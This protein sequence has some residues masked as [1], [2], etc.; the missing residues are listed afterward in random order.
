M[1]DR[2][3]KKTFLTHDSLVPDDLIEGARAHSLGQRCARGRGGERIRGWR[4]W[5]RRLIIEQRRCHDAL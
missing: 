3:A 4:L 5:G 2:Q 1:L